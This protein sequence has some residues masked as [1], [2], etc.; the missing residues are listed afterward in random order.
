M[1]FRLDGWESLHGR[2][3][4][5]TVESVQRARAARPAVELSEAGARALGKRYWLEALR[6]A[7]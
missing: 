1:R 3:E 5:G 7:H 2:G 4:D 6:A